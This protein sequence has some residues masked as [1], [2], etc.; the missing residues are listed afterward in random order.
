MSSSVKAILGT[1]VFGLVWGILMFLMASTPPWAFSRF[2]L[3]QW[4]LWICLAMY[5]VI[6]ARWSKTSLS[7]ILL[8]MA[9]PSLLLVLKSPPSMFYVSCL[10][11]LSWMRSGICFQRTLLG[12]IG[13]ELAICFGGVALMAFFSPR[14]ALSWGL[15]IWLF[16][17]WQSL[18]FLCGN[19]F[20]EAEEEPLIDRFER[21]RRRAEAILNSADGRSPD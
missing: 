3:F 9:L 2:H 8:P 6:L 13:K 4:T 14:T 16:F 20:H 18:Y 7:S 17:L 11:M 15:G 21:A 12:S 10:L 5:G 1:L 19:P